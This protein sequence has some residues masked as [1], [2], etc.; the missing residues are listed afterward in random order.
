MAQKH[1]MAILADDADFT[2]S[3]Y[4]VCP[5]HAT[6]AAIKNLHLGSYDFNHKDTYGDSTDHATAYG[7]WSGSEYLA[8]AGAVTFHECIDTDIIALEVETNSVLVFYRSS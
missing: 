5:A 8:H 4:R 2:G 3:I 6:S 7:G 1:R